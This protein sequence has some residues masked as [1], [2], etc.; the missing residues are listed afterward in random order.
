MTNYNYYSFCPELWNQFEIEANGDY[1]ICCLANNDE[2]GGYGMIRDE[3]GNVMNAGTHTAQEALNSPSMRNHRLQLSRNERPIL[4]RNC[5]DVED[6]TYGNSINYTQE[7]DWDIGKYAVSKRMGDIGKSL[8]KS[9]FYAD[10]LYVTPK[11]AEK[12]TDPITGESKSKIVTLHLRFSNLCNMKCVHCA[13]HSS[14]LWYEDWDDLLRASKKSGKNVSNYFGTNQFQSKKDEHNRTTFETYDNKI[15]WK[16]DIWKKSWEYIAPTLRFLYVTGGEPL[17]SPGLPEHL[18]HLIQNNFAKNVSI[19]FDTNL[20]VINPKLF[21]KLIKFKR[22]EFNISIDDVGDR[23]EVFRFPGKFNRL[24]ENIKILKKLSQEHKNFIVGNLTSCIG[25]LTVYAIPRVS[26]F[27][28]I[29]GCNARFR[30]VEFPQWLDLRVLKIETKLQIIDKLKEYKKNNISNN[31]NLWLD[32]QINFL[33]K[34]LNETYTDKN[35][36]ISLLN[37]MEILDKKRNTD[38]KKIYPEILPII[39]NELI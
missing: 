25:I 29:M 23:Y 20:S 1:K 11:I 31:C 4:C 21:Q 28:E 2:T 30:F 5:Y 33:K 24:I 19:R 35:H 3:N 18:D 26:E 9:P 14:P 15:W 10:G 27:A 22:V 12:I 16:T 7:V 32:R 39:E 36:I 8:P 37:I 34:Y 17:I 13:P 38:W 6:A